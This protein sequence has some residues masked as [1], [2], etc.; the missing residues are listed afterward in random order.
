MSLLLRFQF[1]VND[2]GLLAIEHAQALPGADR[3]VALGFHLVFDVGAEAH[4]MIAAIVLRDEGAD[5]QIFSV[6]QLHHGLGGALSACVRHHALQITHG[7]V[8]V[9]LLRGQ[10]CAQQYNCD[11]RAADG[12][13]LHHLLR[14]AIQLE[15]YFDTLLAFHRDGFP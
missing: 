10:A 1:Q 7:R 8:L 5:L 14:L 2:R 13:G 11:A 9:L 12:P 6:L 3:A 15:G 4:E